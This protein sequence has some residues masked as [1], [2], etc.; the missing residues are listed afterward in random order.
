M[1]VPNHPEVV[2]TSPLG[3]KT[4]LVDQLTIE[5]NQLALTHGLEAAAGLFS[6]ARAAN[7]LRR[8]SWI[9]AN[10][11]AQQWFDGTTDLDSLAVTRVFCQSMAAYTAVAIGD[12]PRATELAEASLA[13]N[14]ATQFPEISA[15]CWAALGSLAYTQGDTLGALSYLARVAEVT[16]AVAQGGCLTE[17]TR[18]YWEGDWID[19]LI[20]AGRTSEAVAAV[21]RLRR[22]G[23][24]TGDLWAIGV[25]ARSE[26]RMKHSPVEA[27]ELFH[28]AVTTFEQGKL[29]FEIARTFCTRGAHF[30]GKKASASF[31]IAEGYRRLQRL[32]ALRW[33]NWSAGL[34]QSESE[35]L[36]SGLNSENG[37]SRD[38]PTED[39]ATLALSFESSE[40]SESSDDARL[41][42]SSASSGSSGA[43]PSTESTLSAMMLRRT[44]EVPLQL[45][46]SELRV[47][48]LITTGS[49][50]KEIAGALFI[51]AKTVDF[52]VQAMYRKAK[53]NNR[54]EFVSSYL[55]MAHA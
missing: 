30:R 45:T 37:V 47:A 10:T 34:L 7:A 38:E 11:D 42:G 26:G 54:V 17:P 43:L 6:W 16:D 29:E 31:D 23:E 12:V 20:D 25:V 52:H 36:H 3:A 27:E 28:Q 19:A 8:G 2:P 1:P 22:H 33:A 4:N 55:R 32:G 53:V 41:S 18:L 15:W 9:E 35:A 39:R 50:Y 24:S 5:L 48:S 21:A 49:T 13:S 14:A 51:S 44:G 40:S 46:P